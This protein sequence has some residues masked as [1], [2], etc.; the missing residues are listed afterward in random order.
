M[1]RFEY[2]LDSI[3]RVRNWQ[4]KQAE[5]RQMKALQVLRLAEADAA[6]CRGKWRESAAEIQ[7]HTTRSMSV[8]FLECLQV[9][10]RGFEQDLLQAEQ[11]VRTA[12]SEFRQASEHLRKLAVVVE[13]L[14]KNRAERLAV[15]KQENARQEQGNREEKVLQ[16]WMKQSNEGTDLTTGSELWEI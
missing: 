16:R 11:K 9:R 1:K 13:A 14:T 15:F 2:R 8:S 5:L 7:T 4:K 12:L 6:L 3:L 10:S